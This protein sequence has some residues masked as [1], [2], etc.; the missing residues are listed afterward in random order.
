MGNPRDEALPMPHYNINYAANH[1]DI[2]GPTDPS[3][4]HP[5]PVQ[6]DSLSL[7]ELDK[8]LEEMGVPNEARERIVQREKERCEKSHQAGN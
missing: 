5:A 8:K 3:I 6:I 2:D 7:E 4:I 1:R